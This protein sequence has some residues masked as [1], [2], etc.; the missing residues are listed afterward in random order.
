MKIKKVA[1]VG[2]G[3][4]GHG[5]ATLFATH[6]LEVILQSR[7]SSRLKWALEQIESNL[8]FLIS[9]GLL[10]SRDALS[11]IRTTTN[12]AD[13]VKDIDYVQESIAENYEA[14]KSIFKQMDTEADENAILAS[15]SSALLMTEVQKSTKRPQRCMIVHPWNP[16]HILPLVE[17]VGGEATSKEKIETVRKFMLELGKIP[18]ILKKEVPG[19]IANRLQAAV[20]REAIDLVDQGVASVED[21]DRALSAG[22]GLRWAVMGPFLIHH[23]GGGGID[24]YFEA[25]RE[26]LTSR[27]RTMATWTSIPNSAIRK[28]VKG[29]R[30]MYVVRTKNMEDIRRWRDDKLIELIRSLHGPEK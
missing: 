19:H 28:V 26:S 27:W 3:I 11:R 2:A 10:D 22:P 1:C 16:P 30:Q 17:L 20:L 25:Y 23:L 14:K 15:S 18:V 21:I 5:W 24:R 12:V 4:I 29:V 6:N 8:N 7:T 9:K 13:A